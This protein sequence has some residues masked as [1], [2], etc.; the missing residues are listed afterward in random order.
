MGDRPLLPVPD[1][2]IVIVPVYELFGVTVKFVE[3][4]FTL[5]EVGPVNVNVVAL[6]VTVT[7][8]LI[9]VDTFPAASLA[10]AYR[11]FDP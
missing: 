2:V 11:V 9:D 4:L 5:P 3:A 6:I 10:Q 7:G 1:G 8:A